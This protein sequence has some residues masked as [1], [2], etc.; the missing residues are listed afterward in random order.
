MK[1]DL[2]AS[3]GRL[4]R[5]CLQSLLAL[6]T[7]LLIAEA[8]A[9]AAPPAV[10]EPTVRGSVTRPVSHAGLLFENNV[11]GRLVVDMVDASGQRRR[12]EHVVNDQGFR[13]PEL[14]TTAPEGT[15]RIA[16]LG[17]SHTFGHGVD[18]T[19]TW[20]RILEGLLVEHS[21]APVEVL[22]AGVDGYDPEQELAWLRKQ[23]LP[24]GPDLVL[25]QLHLN[26]AAV[27]EGALEGGARSAP[28][29]L[30]RWTHKSRA[31]GWI[32]ALR[33]RSCA[34]DRVLRSIHSGLQLAV[35]QETMTTLYVEDQP[36]WQ[37]AREA[38]LKMQ[39]LL[40]ARG[41]RFGVI[42]YPSLFRVRGELLSD[43]AMGY[44]REFLTEQG[45]PVLDTSEVF[46]DPA[47][48]LSELR[49][50]PH[51]FHGNGAANALVAREVLHW[52]GRVPALR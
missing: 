31:P 48:E 27:R 9:R 26:D 30:F 44:W 52:I 40:R 39:Q 3:A 14:S 38:V 24:F 28:G 37:R 45:I 21:P 41:I 35:Y 8:I 4:R 51:D 25:L 36:G 13:G 20:P 10:P 22:N 34:V 23:V 49:V 43:T 2:P 16:A 15:L 29:R 11:G 12:V 42:L 46:S 6:S 18:E 33:S 19:E 7:G 50:H 17:D 1:A 5:R 32:R 47:L